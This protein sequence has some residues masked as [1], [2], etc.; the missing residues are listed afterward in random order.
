MQTLFR[1]RLQQTNL[2]VTKPRLMILELLSKSKEPLTMQEIV[3]KIPEVHFVS[4]YRS[5]DI[6]SKHRL[7]KQVAIGFKTKY[8]LSDDFKPHHHHAVCQ[9]CGKSKP[10]HSK[11]IEALMRDIT[12]KAG[13]LPT[14]HDFEVYGLCKRC[15]IKVSK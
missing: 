8:E 12:L 6:M 2:S 14:G 3:H 9:S 13:L 4:V 1:D 7:L 11:K 10:I 15:Q 5:V